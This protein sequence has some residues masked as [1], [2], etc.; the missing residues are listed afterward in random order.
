MKSLTVF[1]IPGPGRVAGPFVPWIQDISPA[2]S[3]TPAQDKCV[4]HEEDHQCRIMES[5][6]V[7][8]TFQGHL[9]QLPCDGGDT[10]LFQY[11]IALNVKNNVPIS[12]SPLL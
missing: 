5:F 9:V 12:K 4:S 11:H 6:E 7:E 2:K 3:P 1:E 10:Y 8:G